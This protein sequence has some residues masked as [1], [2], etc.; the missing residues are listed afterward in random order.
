MEE[1][2]TIFDYLP[3]SPEEANY[4]QFLSDVFESNYQNEKYQFSFIAFHMLFMCFV[5]Y[6]I[7]KI[8]SIER[9]ETKKLMIFT[10]KAHSHI[11]AHETKIRAGKD[12]PFSPLKFSEENER[13]IMGLFLAIGCSREEIFQL[14]RLVDDRNDVAHSNGNIFYK[15]KESL[16]GKIEEILGCI[17]A[18]QE[19]SAPI[20]EACYRR[21]L[22]DS[23]NPDDR[24]FPDEQ[25]QVRDILVHRNYLSMEDIAVIRALDI[26]TYEAHERYANMQA[27]Q[28]AIETMYGDVG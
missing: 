7:A 24:E 11:E 14:K 19:H 5:Y 20:I 15:T 17:E 3:E 26:R 13:T 25:D 1:A 8:Y 27:L 10:G 6:Q 21:F 28:Q 23:A 22:E 9:E 4:L 2:Q 18:I 12:S 16:D